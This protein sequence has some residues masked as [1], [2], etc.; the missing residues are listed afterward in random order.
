MAANRTD[1]EAL[2]S[3][4]TEFWAARLKSAKDGTGDPLTAAEA[5][6]VAKFLK[7]NNVTAIIKASDTGQ[8]IL[9]SLPF[10]VEEATA[11]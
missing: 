2:H 11:H 6:A 1:L 4:L 3:T 7:D 9:A 5:T 8:S 10:E